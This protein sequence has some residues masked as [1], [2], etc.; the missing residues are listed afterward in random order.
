M[1]HKKSLFS[2]PLLPYLLLAPQVIITILFFIL[3]AFSALQESFY[4]GDAFG[5]TKVFAGFGNFFST[6]SNPFYLQALKVTVIF[7]LGVSLLALISALFLALL[8]NNALRGRSIYKSLLI[9]PYAVAPAIAGIL[10]R[11]LFNPA[12]GTLAYALD[13]IGYHWDY[14]LNGRQAM[15]LVIIAAA[16]QQLS[17]NYVFFLAG[18][19]AIPNSLIQAAAIDGAG[20]FRRFWSIIFPLLSPTTFFL[21]IMNLIYA[22]FNTFGVI[23]TV[24]QGGP[25][26]A[27]NILVY[28]VYNDGFLGLDLG[29]S[30]AQSV[31]LMLIVIF[32][33]VVQFRYIERKVHY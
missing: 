13:K 10:W 27:T 21:L 7:S 29:G 26:N 1:K 30:A 5:I 17:Y 19:Q 12:V 33:T 20:P 23:Q 4:R 28:K 25:A 2:N 24:T 22:F 6:F 16:W 8:T 31:V 3:P 15:L 11:F 9:W 18:L 14:T 32:L